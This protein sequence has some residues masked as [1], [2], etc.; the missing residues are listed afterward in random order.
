MRH[1]STAA[2]NTSIQ[3]RGTGVK[4]KAAPWLLAACI[5]ALG[6]D[7]QAQAAVVDFSVAGAGYSLT[8]A[9]TVATDVPPTD[10]DPTCGTAGGNAC[11][12]DPA[13]AVRITGVSGV[14]S[15]SA[16]G[17]VNAAIGGLIPISP[18]NERDPVFDPLP[19]SSLS[20]VDYAP[21]SGGYFSY[22]NLLFL[23]GSPIDCGTFPF[24]GTF[25]DDFGTA[26]TV[27][28]GYLVNLWGDGDLHGP[29]TTAYGIDVVSDGT[30]LSSSFDGLSGSAVPEPSTWAM[31]LLA[32]GGLGWRLR[33]QRVVGALA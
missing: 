20:F 10:P 29:G 30:L 18:S 24:A 2:N 21:S 6:F 7:A 15:D 27:A 3:V 22:D 26:F 14:F 4:T 16:D 17:I 1:P 11:R 28:G 8:G 31:M 32:L 25:L 13:G 23:A 19:P 33:R 5:A 12:S 9:F